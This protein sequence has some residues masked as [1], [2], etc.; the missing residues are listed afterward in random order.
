MATT[1]LKSPGTITNEDRDTKVAWVDP[2]N[3]ASSN[4]ADAVCDVDKSTYGDWLRCVNFGF[5]TGD[6]PAD[7]TINGIEVLI[8]REGEGAA[9]TNIVDSYI[10]LRNSS[11]QVGDNKADAVTTWPVNDATATYG[12]VDDAWGAGITAAEAILSTFGVDISIANQHATQA[13]HGDIDHVQIRITYTEA[14]GA[15]APTGTL[16]GSLYGPLGGPL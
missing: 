12:A 6:I 4:D 14:G 2:T 11:G 9:S 1:A 3:A 8:E 13:R 15:V 10:V 16:Y 5:T 7:S